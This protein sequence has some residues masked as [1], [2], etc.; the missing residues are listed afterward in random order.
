VADLHLTVRFLR[1][2]TDDGVE[3]LE[4]NIE[5][6][7]RRW[8]L[9][10]EQ[11]A[12]VL[13][14]CWAEHFIGSHAAASGRIIREILAPAVDAARAA[15]ITIVHAPSPTYIEAYPQWVAYAGDR[16]LGL[17]PPPPPAG[18]PPAEFRRREG[19]YEQFARFREPR[20]REWVTDPSRYRIHAA[21]EPQP[22]DFVIKTGDQLHRL[23]EHRKLLHLFYAGFASNICMLYRDYGTRAMS[24]RGYNVIV[25]RDCTTGIEMQE[26]VEG[27]WLTRAALMSIEMS[28]GHST[29]AADL[30]RACRAPT[31]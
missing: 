9:P 7:E 3:C 25:L 23:L 13:V 29:T 19:E 21:L 17:E 30:V 18:W 27:Q 31:A 8:S 10:A 6:A 5:F 16:D 14:D 26:T 20:V 1:H 24:Q 11:A 28:A 4:E 2:G 15:G 22:G 12:L